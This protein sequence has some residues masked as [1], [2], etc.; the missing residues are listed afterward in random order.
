MCSKCYCIVSCGKAKVKGSVQKVRAKDLY[1]ST[2]FLKSR[3]FAESIGNNWDIL[4]A[5]YGLLPPWRLV[6]SYEETVKSKSREEVEQWKLD[7][8]DQV[9]RMV[10]LRKVE[11]LVLLGGEDYVRH[12]N[13]AFPDISFQP[14][15]GLEIGERL[16][17]L[18]YA[19][20]GGCAKRLKE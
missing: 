13:D 10:E 11:T 16:R 7:T 5:K 8:V 4:S 17:W 3:A 14:L 18:K 15:K 19:N 12:L 2:L 20:A 6:E 1:T 9:G